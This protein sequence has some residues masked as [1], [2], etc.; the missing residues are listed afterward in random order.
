MVG[1]WG[2]C[3]SCQAN[4][5]IGSMGRRK[6]RCM[7]EWTG[8]AGRWEDMWNGQFGGSKEGGRKEKR[9]EEG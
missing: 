6:I 8:L 4:E 9:I 7:E 3:V 1:D 2:E 5:W